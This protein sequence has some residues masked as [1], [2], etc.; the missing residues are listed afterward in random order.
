[1]P[2]RDYLTETLHFLIISLLSDYL[3]ADWWLAAEPSADCRVIQHIPF[4]QVRHQIHSRLQH[5]CQHHLVI[6][7][8]IYH[9][10]QVELAFSCSKPR[11]RI[12]E[13]K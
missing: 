4:H 2:P 8:L 9:V 12:G 7:L 1:M 6:P 10:I 5:R 11:G 13:P 3:F